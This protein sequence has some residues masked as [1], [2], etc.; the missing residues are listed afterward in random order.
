[1][2]HQTR[3]P[4]EQGGGADGVDYHFS[5]FVALIDRGEPDPLAGW[6]QGQTWSPDKDTLCGELVAI[7]EALEEYALAQ[8]EKRNRIRS[9]IQS[10]IKGLMSKLDRLEKNG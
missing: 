9:S 6:E 10:K 8:P 3:F 4:K 5:R 2:L 1:M 7:A